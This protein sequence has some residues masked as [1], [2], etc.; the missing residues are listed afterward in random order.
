MK[1]LKLIS[2]QPGKAFEDLP[3]DIQFIID[4]MT[5]FMAKKADLTT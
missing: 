4:I 5:A 3:F 1:H 2:K